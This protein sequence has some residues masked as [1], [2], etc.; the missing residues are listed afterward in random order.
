[1]PRY[2]DTDALKH[3]IEIE[4]GL[5]PNQDGFLYDDVVNEIIDQQPTED[6]SP[7]V[8]GYW[9]G[10]PI[11]GCCTVRCSVCGSAFLDND[12]RW[13]YCPNCGARMDG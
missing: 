6:V 3:C 9:K 2:I 10:K 12:G 11:A 5:N 7:V 13:N 4:V 8:H 1:M